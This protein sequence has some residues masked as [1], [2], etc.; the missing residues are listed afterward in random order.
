MCV[1]VCMSVSG[2]WSDLQS[3]G[4]EAASAASLALSAVPWS[5]WNRPE[6]QTCHCTEPTTPAQTEIAVLYQDIGR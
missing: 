6:D 4:G 3:A 5:Q 2:S 1:C